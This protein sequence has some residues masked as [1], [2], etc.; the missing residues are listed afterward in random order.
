MRMRRNCVGGVVC[1]T[2]I[3]NRPRPTFTR[4]TAALAAANVHA[5]EL[6]VDLHA[7]R[8]AFCQAMMDGCRPRPW[9]IAAANVDAAESGGG[10]PG[11]PGLVAT[12]K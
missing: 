2:R 10:T 12:A 8:E 3:I 6:L 5:A 7:A 1:D 9:P 4:R 11:S